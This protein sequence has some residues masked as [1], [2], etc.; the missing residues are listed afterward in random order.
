MYIKDIPI[1][2][3]SSQFFLHL[4]NLIVSIFLLFCSNQCLMHIWITPINATSWLIL[5]A[6]ETTVTSSHF[7]FIENK[8][9]SCYVYIS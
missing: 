9:K 4:D 8:V 2:S 6:L 1:F 3:I 5:M 7:I